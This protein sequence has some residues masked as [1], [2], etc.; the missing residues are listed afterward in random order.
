MD[1]QTTAVKV[2]ESVRTEASKKDK[3][4][5]NSLEWA[6]LLMSTLTP[7]AVLVIGIMI[8]SNMKE[9]ER[10][11]GL[12]VDIYRQ[13]GGDIQDIYCYLAFVGNW[14]EQTPLNV[15]EHKRSLDRTMYTY[16]PLFSTRLFEAYQKFIGEAFATWQGAG[17]DARI[18]S[19]VATVRGDRAVHIAEWKPEW[20]QRFTGEDNKM[21]QE[22]ALKDFMQQL[23]VDLGFSGRQ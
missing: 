1:E 22:M 19:A 8:S 10:L 20:A 7:I 11:G 18:R 6:K 15:I 3:S 9:T 16:Q 21:K 2:T 23:A 13:I 17:Q 12:R 14:K 4:P 5:W